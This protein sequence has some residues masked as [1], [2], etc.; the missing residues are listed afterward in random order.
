MVDLAYVLDTGVGSARN[1]VPDGRCGV[2]LVDGVPWWFGPHTAPWTPPRPGV[3]VVGVR[4]S[5]TAGHRTA[6]ASLRQWQN[7]RAPLGTVWEPAVVTRLAVQAAHVGS[8]V[9]RVGLLIAATLARVDAA[10]PPDRVTTSLAG[11]VLT[12]TTVAEI[13]RHVGLSP[14][15]V[16]RRCLDEFGL[17]SLAA[18]PHRP[19]PPGRA[20]HRV[21]ETACAR[22]PGRGRR[23]RRPGPPV[24]GGPRDER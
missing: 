10:R 12:D 22:P 1:V 20:A 17:A 3:H 8:D 13:A 14:R 21:R 9:E 24:P 7:T 16:H 15:Q 2:A 18:A 4:L 11:L 6:G 19:R 5:L 23:L